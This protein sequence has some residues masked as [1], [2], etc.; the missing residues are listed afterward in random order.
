MDCIPPG[1]SVHENFQ[2][3]ILEWVAISSSRGS[4]WP[5]DRTHF[6][7]SP[8]LAGRFLTAAP[9][10][11]PCVTATRT[12]WG[13]RTGTFAV[14]AG[15]QSAQPLDCVLLRSRMEGTQIFLGGLGSF[16]PGLSHLAFYISADF[17]NK[18]LWSR[19]SVP[20]VRAKTRKEEVRGAGRCRLL[21]DSDGSPVLAD[22]LQVWY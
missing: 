16:S 10:G 15:S 20:K 14:Y 4:P 2:A 5:R 13:S 8:G 12:C 11:K 21:Q 7:V 1:S 19:I 9:P 18:I 6:S 17:E 22:E 3:R